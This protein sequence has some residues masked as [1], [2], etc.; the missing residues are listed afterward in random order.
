MSAFSSFLKSLPDVLITFSRDVVDLPPIIRCNGGE[1]GAKSEHGSF[2]S[3]YKPGLKV[4]MPA[5]H[6]RDIFGCCS[7]TA[8]PVRANVPLTHL[9][10]LAGGSVG[11]GQKALVVHRFRLKRSSSSDS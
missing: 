9:Q 4:L 11:D 2:G 7:T 8:R 10:P 1:L 5:L 3:T 6:Q